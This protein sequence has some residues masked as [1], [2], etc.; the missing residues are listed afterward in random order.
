MSFTI[1]ISEGFFWC[2]H[3]QA[4]WLPDEL[5]LPDRL[6]G[7]LLLAKPDGGRVLHQRPPGLF[8]G[9]LADWP[10]A[11]R[12]AQPHPGA[13]HRHTRAHHPAHDCPS[14][15]EEQTQPRCNVESPPPGQPHSA[16]TPKL[17]GKRL[18]I[19]IRTGKETNV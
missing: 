6:K 14:G 5:H 11:P 8:Q 13:L 7:A 3:S 16:S 10:A 18:S 12:P 4:V 2:C 19:H 17:K 1:S 9:L 15:V